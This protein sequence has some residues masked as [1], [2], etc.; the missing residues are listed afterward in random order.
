[1]ITDLIH[2]IVGHNAVQKN[3]LALAVVIPLLIGPVCVITRVPNLAWFLALLST[4]ISLAIAVLLQ[5][6][7]EPGV[8]LTYYLGNWPP[9][10]GIEFVLDGASSITLLVMS[11]L[12]FLSTLSAKDL[13][14][15]EIAQAD[16]GKFYG[17][18][19]LACGGLFGL[20][21]TAD[22]FNLFVFLEISALSSVIL[23]S[24]GAGRDRRALVAGYNYLLLG[25]VGATFY[26][27]GV[28]FVYAMTGTLNMADLASRIPNSSSDTVVFVGFAFMVAGILVKAAVFPVHVWLPA[29]YA[30]APSS[31]ST[32]LAA[33]ATKAALYVLARVLFT[34]FS[35]LSPFVSL[36]LDNV[37]IPLA[38]AGV[39][40]GTVMAIY[41][42]D[43]KKLLAQSSVAQ[44]GYIALSFSL[45]TKAGISA[46]F[47]H[48]GNHAI[49]K[50]GLFMAVAS[51]VIS[52]G[53]RT[54]LKEL[55]GI[56]RRMPI[57]GVAFLICGLSL[58]GLPLTA[59]F[60]SKLF[61]IRAIL[62][63]GSF[64]VLSLVLISSVLSLVYLWKIFEI[65]WMQPA[66]MKSPVLVEKPSVYLP[67]WFIA[68]VN[69]WL[70]VDADWLIT[71]SQTA[72]VALIGADG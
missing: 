35:G 68:I 65:M 9:P 70:G 27:I 26:V 48:I 8:R 66:P 60:M 49:I 57:T 18:W 33:I 34:I 15:T 53:M 67:L 11:A 21:L 17:A 29:A 10:W 6:D 4:G 13:V 38:V 58:A 46:G 12:A 56:G 37:I 16:I 31:V 55:R 41:E 64:I 28:G 63:T 62:E 54:N 5:I 19:L 25:A 52:L 59:G 24:M 20:V 32:L 39:F 50:G 61:I 36:A 72:A 1:M 47:V 22:A 69:I 43:I 23:I 42:S 45:A 30:Y 14:A 40:I 2:L 44:I 3:L 7:M 51:F 71:A